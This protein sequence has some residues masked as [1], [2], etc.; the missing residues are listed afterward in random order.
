MKFQI[1][2]FVLM[3]YFIMILFRHRVNQ[4]NVSRKSTV[5]NLLNLRQKLILQN[6]SY[7][8]LIKAESKSVC[9]YFSFHRSVVIATHLNNPITTLET[10]WHA[11]LR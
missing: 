2:K 6:I 7:E 11:Q 10:I 5:M 3:I 1:Q 9:I 4:I 8:S